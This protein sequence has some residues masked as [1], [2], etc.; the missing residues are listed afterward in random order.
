V[1]SECVALTN[2]RSLLVKSS[3]RR[4]IHFRY[5]F[6][7]RRAT[8]VVFATL[9]LICSDRFESIRITKYETGTS[10]NARVD[11]DTGS[12]QA[13]LLSLIPRTSS[14]SASHHF[15]SGQAKV[16]ETERDSTQFLKSCARR[17]LLQILD[18]R[19]WMSFRPE[20]GLGQSA[21]VRAATT[22]RTRD[23]LTEKPQNWR[24]PVRWNMPD[25]KDILY[26]V[27]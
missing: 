26:L 18:A 9:R 24:P 16:H 6:E 27:F 11:A 22:A 17:A 7:T 4:I 13:G 3:S 10:R 19:G 20:M 12:L 21:L 25:S 23:R 14:K 8:S 5:E 1:T 15:T 2:W